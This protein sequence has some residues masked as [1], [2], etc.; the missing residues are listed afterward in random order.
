[1]KLI[2]WSVLLAP[3]LILAQTGTENSPLGLSDLPSAEA[4]PKL[5]SLDEPAPAPDVGNLQ[6]S[7][8]P[9]I[10]K[11]RT[12]GGWSGRVRPGGGGCTK[13]SGGHRDGRGEAEGDGFRRR[14]GAT[15]L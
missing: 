7:P 2:L 9:S 6:P 1:M 8:S 4:K 10:P 15:R 14:S 11:I 13:T 3:G 5:P 12:H